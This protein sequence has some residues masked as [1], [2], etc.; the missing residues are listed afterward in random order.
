MKTLKLVV[1]NRRICI[2]HLRSRIRSFK[3]VLVELGIP[4]KWIGFCTI[5][6]CTEFTN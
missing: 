3:S 1:C 4:D 5:W 6:F 2:D